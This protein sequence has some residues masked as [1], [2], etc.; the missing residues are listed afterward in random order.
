M[1]RLDQE[2]LA[3]EKTGPKTRGGAVYD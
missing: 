2:K 3:R 1:E